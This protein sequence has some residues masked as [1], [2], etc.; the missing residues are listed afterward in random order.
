MSNDARLHELSTT[1]FAAVSRVRRIETG[2]EAGD[3]NA[4]TAALDEA[5]AA[6]REAAGI[7]ADTADGAAAQVAIIRDV[8]GVLG[9]DTGELMAAGGPEARMLDRVL[10]AHGQRPLTA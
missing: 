5:E 9:G 8:A 4:I 7:V 2:H 1:Y 3:D 6:E 10:E